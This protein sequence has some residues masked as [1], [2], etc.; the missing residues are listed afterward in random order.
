ML[1]DLPQDIAIS[2]SIYRAAVLVRRRKLLGTPKAPKVYV[3]K[4]KLRAPDN[5]HVLAFRIHRLRQK[6]KLTAAEY[7]RLRSLEFRIDPA[8]MLGPSRVH[9]VTAR[10]RQI[11]WELRTERDMTLSQIAR[12]FSRDHTT[13]LYSI[14]KAAAEKGDTQAIDWCRHRS[15]LVK[16]N[17][18]RKIEME[19][20][21]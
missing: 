6:P 4:P 8:V 13:V 1:L 18:L 16:R 2:E 5:D 9:T 17:A 11:M 19:N 12:V 7:V 20:A 15:E 21:R 14:S 3:P 10:R